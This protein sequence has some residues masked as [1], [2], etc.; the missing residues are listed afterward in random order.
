MKSSALFPTRLLPAI[1]AAI[2]LQT[3]L[4][5][6]AGCDLPMFAGARLFAAATGTQ[7]M[8]TGDFNHDGFIDVV[9]TSPGRNMISVLLSNGDGTFQP[10]INST[11]QQPNTVVV[12][13]FNGDGKLDLAIWS[14]FNTVVMLGNGDGTFKA[15]T[16][17]AA[18]GGAM[19]VGDFNGDGKPDL[20]IGGPV[21]TI[22][23]RRRHLSASDI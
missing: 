16:T 14:S 22:G 10:A 7:Y 18:Q 8:A 3:Q 2:L 17:A 5:F 21:H 23:Q 20:A 9:V 15:A 13:D 1:L 4:A 12:A 6:A 11:V 19:A